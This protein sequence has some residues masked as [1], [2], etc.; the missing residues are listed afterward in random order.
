MRYKAGLS[1]CP[2][3]TFMFHGLLTGRIEVDGC[4]I[5]F[6]LLDIQELNERV[7]RGVFHFSKVSC[8]AAAR[9]AEGYDRCPVGAAL[10]YG[11][12]P[13][14]VGRPGHRVPIERARIFTPGRDTTAHLLL[15]AFYPGAQRVEHVVFSEIMP[16]LQRGEVDYGVVIHEGRFTFKE[17]GLSLEADLGALWEERYQVPLP[18]GCL[19][20][21]RRVPVADRLAFSEALRKSIEY[22]MA[23][24][25]EAIVSMRRYA[26]ELSDDVLWRHVDLY[27]NRWSLELGDEGARAFQVFDRLVVEAGLR[28]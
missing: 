15:R 12:G 14:L 8:F 27:V 22:G 26:Q 24:R 5:E 18:L 6:E 10:G 25:D 21:D 11:V 1:T 13:L 17:M 3:D 19:I 20:L 2:N 28:T 9:L 16:A 7:A 23:H 4:D